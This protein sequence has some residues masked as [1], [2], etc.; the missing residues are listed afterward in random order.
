[1][2]SITEW[3]NRS[4]HSETLASG[5]PLA[6]GETGISDMTDPHDQALRDSGVLIDVEAPVD[7]ESLKVDKLAELAEGLNVKGTGQDGRIVK[8]DYITALEAAE[9]E[10]SR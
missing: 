2:T 10:S 6:P 3:L 1:M 4:T 9:K 7:Y 5:Q 8:Q